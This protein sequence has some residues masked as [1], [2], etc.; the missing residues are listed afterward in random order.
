MKTRFLVPITAL[1]VIMSISLVA[2][3][4][5][6]CPELVKRAITAV[7]KVCDT[8]NGNEACYGNDRLQA[9]LDDNA[10][11]TQPA[12][13]VSVGDIRSLHTFGLD[14][15]AGTWGIAVLDVQANLPDTLPVKPSNSSSMGMLPYRTP[16]VAAHLNSA[17]CRPSI[18]HQRHQ[19]QL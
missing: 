7:A 13:R 9:E 6:D 5:D 1:L 18:H 14:E 8:L 15:Q 17:R 4:T 11:F 19:T 10:P 3:Q 16:P 12:D 2:A